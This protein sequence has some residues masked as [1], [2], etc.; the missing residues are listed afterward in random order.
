MPS[1]GPG[2]GCRVKESGRRRACFE[3][4]SPCEGRVMSVAMWIVFWKTLFLAK[5]PVGV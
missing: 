5:V 3:S 4:C 2:R 1:L